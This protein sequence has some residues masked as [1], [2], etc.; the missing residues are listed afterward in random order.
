MP[1]LSW[2]DDRTDTKLIELIP[3]LKLLSEVPDVRPVLSACCTRD[4]VYLTDKSITMCTRILE[5][6]KSRREKIDGFTP[7]S[8][9]TP[10]T[11]ATESD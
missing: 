2:Y 6:L 3:V 8:S 4:N 11:P 10:K 5:D 9:F 1:I 7:K